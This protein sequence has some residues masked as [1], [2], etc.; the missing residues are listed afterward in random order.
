[1]WRVNTTHNMSTLRNNITDSKMP[2]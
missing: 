2:A 1:M